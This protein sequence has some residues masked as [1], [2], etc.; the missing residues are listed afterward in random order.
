VKKLRA[1]VRRD[2]YIACRNITSTIYIDTTDRFCREL[3]GQ[4]N[5]KKMNKRIGPE[6]RKLHAKQNSRFYP[7]PPV[8][9][10]EMSGIAE[11]I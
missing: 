11:T 1:T 2:A 5:E 10:D 6:S 7:G 9:F 3:K 4:S 8:V